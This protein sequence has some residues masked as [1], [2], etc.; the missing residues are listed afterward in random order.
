MEYL[1]RAQGK[2]DWHIARP[3]A[4]TAI[5][6]SPCNTC[7]G[8]GKEDYKIPGDITGVM[9]NR[10]CLRCKGAGKVGHNDPDTIKLCWIG[11]DEAIICFAGEEDSVVRLPD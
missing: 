6:E 9:H 2:H 8:S 7:G 1:V 3:D 4:S 5:V 11:R 10:T